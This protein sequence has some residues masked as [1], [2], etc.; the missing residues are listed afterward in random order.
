MVGATTE[1]EENA[2]RSFLGTFEILELSAEIASQAIAIPEAI[3]PENPRRD[4]LCNSS[5]PRLHVGFPQHQGLETGMA[6]HQDSL[7]NLMRPKA[8]AIG[9]GVSGKKGGGFRG[10]EGW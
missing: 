5:N 7:P 4:R 1:S 8:R 10:V 2:I 9:R 3:P 6:R